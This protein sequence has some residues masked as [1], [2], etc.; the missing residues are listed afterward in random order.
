MSGYSKHP[1]LLYTNSM[2]MKIVR[3]HSH[4]L[5]QKMKLHEGFFVKQ[6]SI[7]TKGARNKFQ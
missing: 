3:T 4:W 2:L 5:S 7:M 1:L 6:P